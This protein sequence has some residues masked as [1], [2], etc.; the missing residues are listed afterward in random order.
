[1]VSLESD[2]AAGVLDEQRHFCELARGDAG[3]EIIAA[4]GVFNTMQLDKKSQQL[5]PTH[6]QLSLILMLSYLAA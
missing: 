4:K 3:L 6:L 1:M 5:L 2:K